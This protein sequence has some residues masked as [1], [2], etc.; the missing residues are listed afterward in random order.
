MIDETLSNKEYHA[1]SDTSSSQI[2]YFLDSPMKYKAS[3]DGEIVVEETDSMKFGTLAH[4]YILERLDQMFV[5]DTDIVNAVLAKKDYA[6]VRN[7]KDYKNEVK[8]VK[9]QGKFLV[10]GPDMA[11]L[12]GMRKQVMDI[13]NCKNCLSLDH[14][15]PEVSFFTEVD[16]LRIKARADFYGE[17]NGKIYLVDYK[18]TSSGDFANI[19]Q[20]IGKWGYDIQAAHYKKV[21]EACVGKPVEHFY[22]IF[23]QKEAPYEVAFVRLG[24]E[25]MNAATEVLEKTYKKIIAAICNDDFPSKYGTKT[26]QMESPD[27]RLNQLG[28]ML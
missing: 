17:K 23:Q 24:D 14:G 18:T 7:T 21:V 1:T 3:L 15:K 25:T 20:A 16:G 10:K 6:N 26:V 27:W 11:K 8:V 5:D 2:R 13:P 19:Q 9:E 4:S 28:A 12:K 22:F